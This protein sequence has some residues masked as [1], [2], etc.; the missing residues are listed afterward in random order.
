MATA[1]VKPGPDGRPGVDP[2]LSDEVSRSLE[3]VLEPTEI[4]KIPR[5][6]SIFAVDFKRVL[7]LVT[8]G[9]AG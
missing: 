4:V 1:V 6:R 7:S 8:A 5:D 9:I 3:G 2:P